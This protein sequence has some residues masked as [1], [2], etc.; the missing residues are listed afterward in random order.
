MNDKP[1]ASADKHNPTPTCCHYSRCGV[2]AVVHNPLDA[3]LILG[4]RHQCVRQGNWVVGVDA[5]V[6]ALGCDAARCDSPGH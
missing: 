5:A 3:Q 6:A 4:L 1:D 2:I